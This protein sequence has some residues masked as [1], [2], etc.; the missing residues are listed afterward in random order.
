MAKLGDRILE[1]TGGEQMN[2]TLTTPSDSIQEILDKVGKKLPLTTSFNGGD[3]ARR[4]TSMC[5][6]H[7][8]FGTKAV[9]CKPPCSFIP[10][11]KN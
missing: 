10:D 8:K 6:Y 2:V 1:V 4:S 9:R 5:W 7:A 3:Q 11:P